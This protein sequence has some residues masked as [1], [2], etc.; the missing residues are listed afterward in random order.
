MSAG[1]A[2]RIKDIIN[3]SGMSVRRLADEIGVSNVSIY[4]W[5]NNRMT[6]EGERLKRFCDYFKVTPAFIIYG[7]SNDE[8]GQSIA[9]DVNRISIPVL[10][11]QACCGLGLE[12]PPNVPIVKMIDVDDVFFN[13]YLRGA[14]RR[15]LH[16]IHA[17]GDSMTPTI[18]E[19]CPVIVDTSDKRLNRDGIFAFVFNSGLFIKRVQCLPDGISLLSDNKLYD[20]IKI[21]EQDSVK[22]VGRCYCGFNIDKF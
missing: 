20:P 17:V 19:G 7:D 15:S 2:K 22:V 8:R 9:I 14:N 16:I 10:D 11:I 18:K 3:Q 12:I 21:T 5:I 1:S 4:K 6:P 13:E